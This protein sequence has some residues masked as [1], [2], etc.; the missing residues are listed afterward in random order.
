M[1]ERAFVG[2]R[3]AAVLLQGVRKTYVVRERLGLLRGTKRREI[4]SL[5]GVDLPIESGEFLALL[6]R[7]GAGKT[8]LLKIV[9]TLLLPSAGEVWVEGYDAVRAPK[10]VRKRIGVVL[11]GERTLY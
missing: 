5:R 6:G 8:T 1:P 10:E 3:P 9:A 2:D 4:P 11:A 7:N